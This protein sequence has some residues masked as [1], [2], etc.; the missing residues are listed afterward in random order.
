MFRNGSLYYFLLSNCILGNFWVLSNVMPWNPLLHAEVLPEIQEIQNIVKMISFLQIR[1]SRNLK[2]VEQVCA[3]ILTI[4]RI[5]MSENA[6]LDF[7]S[8]A[9]LKLWNWRIAGLVKLWNYDVWK[10]ESS[11]QLALLENRNFCKIV[12]VRSKQGVEKAVLFMNV[13]V[14]I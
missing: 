14:K 13:Y 8:S 6:L 12:K 10:L 1:E 5:E 9:T 4:S 11:K 7:W 2:I 3:N